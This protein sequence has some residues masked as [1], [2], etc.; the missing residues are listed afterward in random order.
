MYI[1]RER[2]PLFVTL[3]DGSKLSRS[4]LPDKS[5]KRWVARRKAV[6]VAAVT[7]GLIQ[8]DEACEIYDLT[9]EELSGWCRAV[10]C[11]GTAALRITSLQHYRHHLRQTTER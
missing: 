11:H 2:G 1:R 9:E 6:V 3:P 5:I 7:G 8:S 10:K 4:D